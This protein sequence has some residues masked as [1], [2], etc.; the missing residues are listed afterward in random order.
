MALEY[1][2]ILCPVEF[3][4]VNFR[5]A[6]NTAAGLVRETQGTLFV[7][8]AFPEIVREPAGTKLYA[9]V[10]QAQEDYARSK[11]AEIER[12]ELSGI[13]HEL[14]VMLGDPAET[15]EGGPTGAGR[16]DR[17]GNARAT[18]SNA[19]VPRQRSGARPSPRSV[20]DFGDSR[21]GYR[22]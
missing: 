6:L 13:K 11:M 1:R 20:P 16:F 8:T 19:S 9:A 5:I 14:L 21:P 10:N 22:T 4:D 15:P 3:D 18:W 17:D 2:K 7:L 12:K